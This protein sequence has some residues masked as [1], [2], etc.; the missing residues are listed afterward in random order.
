[1]RGEGAHRKW[2]CGVRV[3]QEVGMWGEAHTGSGGEGSHRKCGWGSK[4]SYK[5]WG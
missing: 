3:T 2:G 1:M 5:K 4:G